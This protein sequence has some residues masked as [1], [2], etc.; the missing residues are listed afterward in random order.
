MGTMEHD[1]MGYEDLK[2]DTLGI[3]ILFL[4]NS[5]HIILINKV[6]CNHNSLQSVNKNYLQQPTVC[7]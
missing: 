5:V 6:Y 2:I 1:V 3:F 4:Y 7:Q